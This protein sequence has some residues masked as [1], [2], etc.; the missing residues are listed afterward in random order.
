TALQEW[1]QARRMPPPAYV[2][3]ART[4]PDH[5]PVFTIEVQLAS[6]E[7]ATAT[8]GSKRKAEQEAAA[9]LLEQVSAGE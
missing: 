1:A 5:A 7:T 4:G 3:T 6:G 9:A 2:E 8:A